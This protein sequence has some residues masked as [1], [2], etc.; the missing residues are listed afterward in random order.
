MRTAHFEA[1]PGTSPAARASLP[2]GGLPGGAPGAAR[3]DIDIV[4]DEAGFAALA[5][6]WRALEAAADGR[7]ALPVA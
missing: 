5:Q 2:G 6:C 3:L 1:L 7:D 4:A